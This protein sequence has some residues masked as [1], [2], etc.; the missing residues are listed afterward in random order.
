MAGNRERHRAFARPLH[1]HGHRINH[2]VGVRG[3]RFHAPRSGIDS[4]SRFAPRAHGLRHRSTRSGDGLGGFEASRLSHRGLVRQRSHR[5][6]GDRWLD[7]RLGASHRPGAPRRRPADA[8]SFRSTLAFHALDRQHSP[9]RKISDGGFFLRRWASRRACKD[10]R[11][12][13]TRRAH[14]ERQDARVQHRRGRGL[15]RRCDPAARQGAC[16]KRQPGR[17]A[18]Q[19]GPRRRGDQARSG[20]VKVAQAHRTGDRVRGL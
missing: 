11:S 12:T 16:G 10:Q 6:A 1:D 8:G 14:G 13:L 2:D 3:A 18:R 20:R 17:A 9:R 4:R 5:R 19:P 15:Q 7:Q